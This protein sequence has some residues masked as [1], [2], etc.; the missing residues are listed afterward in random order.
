MTKTA[1][2]LL[3]ATSALF[4]IPAHA[5]PQTKAVKIA[6]LDLTTL[7]GRQALERRVE[8]AATRVCDVPEAS[9]LRQAKAAER[10]R[11]D[12]KS[13]ALARAGVQDAAQLAAR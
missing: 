2:L 4:A 12:A 8:Q 10:C 1:A 9:P 13:A 7:V 3:A 5:T 11:R 6:D